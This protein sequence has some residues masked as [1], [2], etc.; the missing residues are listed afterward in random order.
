MSAAPAT[1]TTQTVEIPSA[2]RIYVRGERDLID[3][4]S[5]HQQPRAPNGLREDREY[6]PVPE[7]QAPESWPTDEGYPAYRPLNT[8]VDISRRAWGATGPEI[9]FVRTMLTGVL[10]VGYANRIYRETVGRIAPK[11]WWNYDVGGQF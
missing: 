11:S 8:T 9:V 1:A 2:D 7:G 6:P 4:H 3:A 10:F 5:A